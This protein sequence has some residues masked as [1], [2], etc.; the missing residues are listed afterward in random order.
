[1]K[2]A[3]LVA[4]KGIIGDRFFNWKEEYNGQVTFFAFEVYEALCAQLNV[5][6]KPPS[7][8]RR[9]IIVEGLDL[10]TLI[11][12]EFEVQGVRFRGMCECSP[13]YWMDKAFASG[14]EKA[15]KDR[16]GLRARVLTSGEVRA[17]PRTVKEPQH[18]AEAFAKKRSRQASL[19]EPQRAER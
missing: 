10:G 5:W 14:A 15:M 8:F 2:T 19:P 12:R 4:G 13:C 7:V 3:A 17:E 6:D 16:G 1:M 9:N 11:G 18:A